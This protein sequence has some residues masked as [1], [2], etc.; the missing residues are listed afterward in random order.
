[1][2]WPIF[3]FYTSRK[4]YLSL[5][6]FFARFKRSNTHCGAS[7]LCGTG[8][9]ICQ[10]LGPGAMSRVSRVI[11]CQGLR[12]NNI[13]RGATTCQ[14]KPFYGACSLFTGGG[15]GRQCQLGILCINWPNTQQDLQLQNL[16]WL[17]FD[18][19]EVSGSL[20]T[21]YIGVLIEGGFPMK[22]IGGKDSQIKEWG[23]IGASVALT[24]IG[25]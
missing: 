21:D 4:I 23:V 10:G 15:G 9:V 5:S 16:F 13:A 25:G 12:G 20:L 1:M 14:P 17:S 8:W 24:M 22:L 7:C 6:D 18:F 2:T 11:I 3:T 19:L